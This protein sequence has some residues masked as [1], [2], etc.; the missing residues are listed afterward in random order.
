MI[1]V[2]QVVLVDNDLDGNARKIQKL[3]Q[4]GF[5]NNIKVSVNAGIALLYLQQQNELLKDFTQ[6]L[7][8]NVD[9]PIMNGFE[10][11][12]E[13][14]NSKIVST[15]NIMIAILSDNLTTSQ[16][17]KLKIMGIKH[18][19]EEDFC[20]ETLAKSVKKYFIKSCSENITP[21]KASIKG[22]EGLQG[23]YASQVA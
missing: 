17:D 8:V 13:L 9:T 20:V 15:K 5:S 23:S 22:L 2:H 4:I 1:C 10:F 18:F 12:S 21:G 14:K 6:L 7:I 11:L 16:M 3:N 19:I